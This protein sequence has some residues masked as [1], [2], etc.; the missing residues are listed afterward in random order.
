MADTATGAFSGGEKSR[1][2]LALIVRRRPNLLLLDEPTNHLDLEMRHALMRALAEY[3]GSLVL[4][5]HDRALLRTVC[6]GFL[7][8]ADGRATEFA[9]DLDDYLEWL[10]ER[11]ARSDTASPD[12]PAVLERDARR[13]L[14]ETAGADR[15]ARLAR[16]RPLAREAVALEREVETLE[17]EKRG[18]EARLADRAFYS[19]ANLTEVQATT[20]RCADIGRRLEEAESR[21]LELQAELEAIGEA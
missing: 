10:A 1:L 21:W 6:D 7:L 18:L 3:E 12:S 11:R 19:A 8:V 5:S 15:Q 14:R 13:A 9:G 4:V 2:A 20:R 17:A 16:R